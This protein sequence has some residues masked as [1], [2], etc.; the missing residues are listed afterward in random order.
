MQDA[1]A[2]A[3]ALAQRCGQHDADHDKSVAWALHDLPVAIPCA[4]KLV[5]VGWPGALRHAPR[6]GGGVF[7]CEPLNNATE[8]ML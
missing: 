7:Q 5:E 1:S 8:R 3:L 6:H 4:S 2:P